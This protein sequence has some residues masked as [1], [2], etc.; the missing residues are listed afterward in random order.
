MCRRVPDTEYVPV[1]AL[2]FCAST[3]ALSPPAAVEWNSP[4]NPSAN[5]AVDSAATVLNA[6]AASE[7]RT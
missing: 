5:A 7:R 1:T 6:S 2:P 3:S 4:A